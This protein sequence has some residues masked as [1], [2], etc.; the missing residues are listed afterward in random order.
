MRFD[1]A[2]VGRVHPPWSGR[3]IRTP[4]AGERQ[5]GSCEAEISDPNAIDLS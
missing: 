2:R 1:A 5:F 3:D 4:D